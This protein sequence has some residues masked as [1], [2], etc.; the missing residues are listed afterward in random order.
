MYVG[1]RS[2]YPIG[3]FGG[4]RPRLDPYPAR[5]MRRLAAALPLLSLLAGA[6]PAHAALVG[7][8]RAC[9]LETRSTNVTVNGSG[10]AASRPYTV[11]L[12]GT[13]LAGGGSMTDANGAMQG[14]ISPPTLSATESERTHTLGV[15]SDGVAANTM[16][17]VTKFSA[18]FAPSR[19]VAP[20]S[21]VRFSVYGFALSSPTPDVYLHYVDPAGKLRKTIRLG[22]AQGQCGSIA[23]T[24]KRRLFPFGVPRRGKWQLQFDTAR[25][26]TRGERGSPFLFYTIGVNVRTTTTTTAGTAQSGS[27]GSLGSGSGRADGGR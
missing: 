26:Y 18:D 27:R 24:A 1:M 2:F 20:D 14:A 7:T 21:R 17:T 22:R 11:A 16:F 5:R 15:E 8:D 23:R 10:F 6:A 19:R 9:Y 25:T 3:V 12:D 13:P 4:V